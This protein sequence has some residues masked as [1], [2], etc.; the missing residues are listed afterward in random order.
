[1]TL[2]E[3]HFTHP[4]DQADPT[5]LLIGERMLGTSQY[6]VG[7]LPNARH[8]L[9][10]VLAHC[11]ASL[12]RAHIIRFQFDLPVATCG[13][14]VRVLW[15]QGFPDQAMRMTKDNIED[16]RAIDD[17]VSL[18]WALDA[19]CMVAIAVGD[20]ATA[21]RSV[22]M[23]LK[24]SAKHALGFWQALGHSYEGQVLIMRGDVLDGVRCLRA[25]LDELRET[26]YV[27][28]TPA[29][30][31]ALA[32]GM[33]G[34]G[35]LP[36]ALLMIDEALTRCEHTHERW[37][38]AELLRVKGEL[39]LLQGA[40]GATTAAEDHFRKAVDWARRQGAL[41]LELRVA[42]SLARLLSD[43]GRA[44]EAIAT[45]RPVYGRFIEGFDTIDLKSA[46]AV[47]DA[48]A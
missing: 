22:A 42:T 31:G 40:Q 19:A 34:A 35:Q 32:E 33:A 37:S 25:G 9:E 43:Q 1:L 14:L 13:T 28:R 2:A 7:D 6:Y 10:H 21:E 16:A 3:R 27:L 24:Y 45:L 39:L 48:L 12:R 17:V 8:H 44:G 26:R 29:L 30:L 20:H 36:P 4:R 18:F 5:D 46:K 41:A 11:K 15:L 47:L 23:L 38:I